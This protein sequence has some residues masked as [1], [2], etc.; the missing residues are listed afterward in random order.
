M[1]AI[2]QFTLS[3][4]IAMPISKTLHTIVV[5]LVFTKL[6]A[7]D[8]SEY[9]IDYT[10]RVYKSNVKSMRMHLSDWEVSSPIM[11]LG[12]DNMLMFSFDDIDGDSKDYYY[13]VIH[14]THDWQASNLMYFEYIDGFEGLPIDDYEFSF[15]TFIQYTHYSI[16]L[17]NQDLKFRYSGNYLLVVYQDNDQNNVV[18]TKRFMVVDDLL[19]IDAQVSQ[20]SYSLLRDRGQKIDFTLNTSNYKVSDPLSELH[21]VIMQNNEW[22]VIIDDL[23]PSF[24]NQDQI[25]YHH[26]EKNTFLASNEFRYF[27]FN[28][29]RILSERI[30]SIVYKDPYYNIELFPDDNNLFVP[31]SSVDD[32]N[33]KYVIETNRPDA[34]GFPEIEADYAIV[35]FS[36]P[37]KNNI[38]GST[39]HIYGELCNYRLDASS[40]MEYNLESKQYEKYLLLKQG[41][42]NYRYVVL[43]NNG[44]EE[45]DH[46][47][48]EGHHWQTENDYQLFVYHKD[49]RAGYDKLVGY[50]KINSVRK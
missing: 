45:P 9:P 21:V 49:I 5:L 3:L 38:P 37:L 20:S 32:I 34:T 6:W 35:K 4:S 50:L 42:Y 11:H 22:D 26:E 36:L 30:K 16:E 23:E 29:M 15:S 12:G 31:Y 47:F 8:P 41:Y 28:N 14:C 2:K 39:V 40:T 17:P 10:D 25:V 7:I 44:S 46:G 1:H 27:S 43:S 19:N 13:T 24:I 18:C 48:F 33:G